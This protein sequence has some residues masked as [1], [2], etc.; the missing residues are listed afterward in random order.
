MTLIFQLIFL[1][2]LIVLGW[3]VLADLAGFLRRTVDVHCA[4]KSRAHVRSQDRPAK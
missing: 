2:A 4:K 3:C 1:T